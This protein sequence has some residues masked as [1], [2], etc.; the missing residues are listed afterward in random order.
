MRN[1]GKSLIAGLAAL[2]L[3]PSAF[4][5]F[6]YVVGQQGVPVFQV[7]PLLQQGAA[8]Q[9]LLNQAVMNQAF[10]QQA[11]AARVGAI[12]GLP[13]YLGSGTI[14]STPAV[15]GTYPGGNGLTSPNFNSGYGSGYGYGQ[16]YYI[17]SPQGASLRGVA[18]LTLAYGRYMQ[19]Y[20]R[21]RLLN[22]E[23][24]RSRIVTRRALIEEWR[25]MQSL[26]PKAEDIRRVE[27]E[28]DLTR[29]TKQAPIGEVLAGKSLNVLLTHL[30]GFH[31]NGKR[32]PAVPTSDDT[33]LQLNVSTKA[34]RNIG[35]IKTGK[36]NWPFALRGDAFTKFREKIDDTLPDA[37]NRAKING[38]VDVVL[39]KDLDTARQA[40][41]ETLD[42]VA[43]DLTMAQFMESR[44]ALG[45]LAEGL[46]ALEEADVINYFNGKYQVKG[47]TIADVVDYM[48]REGLIFVSAVPGDEGAYRTMYAWMLAYYEAISQFASR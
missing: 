40:M 15:S 1:A 34:G 38:R 7:N 35:Y 30:K 2:C 23:V 17:E 19:D 32:G 28:R 14:T 31:G 9:A 18:D 6:P 8:N 37:I 48:T 4:G 41:E 27:I 21:A 36:I 16:P 12:P 22:E 13:N 33:L 44:R 43:N 20:Q 47:K 26:M 29:A 45:F 5:Q 3:G 39:L 46:R 10:N 25:Y 24:E 11:V 42:K